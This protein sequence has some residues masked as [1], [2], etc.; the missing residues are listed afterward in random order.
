[1]EATPD[2]HSS[3]VLNG[4]VR[5]TIDSTSNKRKDQHS[6]NK[7]KIET[8]GFSVQYNKTNWSFKNAILA[9]YT[10]YSYYIHA[11]LYHHD[12]VECSSFCST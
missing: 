5:A 6:Y 1:M 11:N 2:A 3:I 10:L 4:R 8:H 7:H 12:T 9:I